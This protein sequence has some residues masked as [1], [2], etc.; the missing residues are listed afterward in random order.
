MARR[1]RI[2]TNDL[3]QSGIGDRDWD[4]DRGSYQIIILS[5]C[6]GLPFRGL[7]AGVGNASPLRFDIYS[8]TGRGGNDF[9][10]RFLLSGPLGQVNGVEARNRRH[11]G[12]NSPAG[13]EKG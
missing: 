5:L 9:L 3:V 13:P 12:S 8:P 4:R 7:G 11:N 2:C 1:I 10:K 6:H